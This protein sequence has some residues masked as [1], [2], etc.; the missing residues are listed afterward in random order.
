MKKVLALPLAAS[1]LL[2]AC[3]PQ[4][5]EETAAPKPSVKVFDLSQS[6]AYEV[7]EIGQIKAA[8]EVELIAQASGTIGKIQ[9]NV[10]DAV[11]D[12][13]LIAVIDFDESNNPARVNFDN[14]QIQLSNAQANYDQVRANN[15]DS[16]TR[17]QLRVQTLR[18]TLERLNRNLDELKVSNQSTETTLNLQLENAEKNLNTAQVNYENLIAQFEQSWED[19]LKSTETSLNSVLTSLSINFESIE[20]IINPDNRGYFTVS[21]LNSGLGAGKSSTRSGVVNDYNELRIAFP[22]AKEAYQTYLPISEGNVNFAIRDVRDS[23]ESMRT[24]ASEVRSM[25]NNSVDNSQLSETE[26]TSYTSSIGTIETSIL[27]NIA[28]LDALE[29]SLADFKLNRV[30]QISTSENNTVI[31]SNQLAD[32]KNAVIQF[33]TTSQGSVQDLESQIVSTQ[34]D[35]LSSEADLASAQRNAGISNNSVNLEIRTLNNQLRLAQDSL[36]NNQLTSPITGLLSEFTVDEG[37][38]VSIGTNLGKVIQSESVKIVFYLSKENAGALSVGQPF[39]FTTTINDGR[40]FTGNITK[41]APAADPINKKIKIEGSTDNSDLYL[42]PEM[43]INLSL[44]LSD[45]TFDQSRVYAPMNAVL[46]NQ[47][48]QFVYVLEEGRAQKRQVEVGEVYGSWIEVMSGITQADQLII[49]GQRNL[50]F[51]GDV[52]VN[53]IE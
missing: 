38:Y 20:E 42:K 10:G 8:Q 37:D 30:S 43:Y 31:S 32:A 1:L 17:S 49:E 29:K 16:I 25:L 23:T 40:E 34:N 48:S 5:V 6:P 47:S 3:S 46:F 12:G 11:V 7:R 21:D 53:V 41:I 27:S 4:I 52:E 33:E 35:L 26:L 44:D 15:Q 24:F 18:E 45:Q 2:S 50:P 51:A 39:G 14:A 36:N 13:D 22:N 9:K 19:L 28:T